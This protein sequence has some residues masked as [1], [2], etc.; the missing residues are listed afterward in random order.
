ML[1]PVQSANSSNKRALNSFINF[2]PDLGRRCHPAALL[3]GRQ[4]V[5]GGAREDWA[6]CSLRPKGLAA[7]ARRQR[8]TSSCRSAPFAPSR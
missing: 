4:V 8:P 3:K 1:C 6:C 7:V 2:P 5:D